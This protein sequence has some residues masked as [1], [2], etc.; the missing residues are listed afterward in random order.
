MSPQVQPSPTIHPAHDH[1]HDHLPAHLAEQSTKSVI[2]TFGKICGAEIEAAAGMI[3]CEKRV[4][5]VG[6]ISFVGDLMWTLALIL[7]HDSAEVIAKKFA[8]FDIPFDCDDMGDVVGE[9][10][11]VLAGV[12]CGNLETVGIKTN[13]SLPTVARGDAFELM[14]PDNLVSK[15]YYFTVGETDFWIDITA[16][17]SK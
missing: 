13:M 7:P 17:K 12:L 11:N 6:I 8:G 3:G 9:L 4:R 2:D 16:M 15:R 14:L 1:S 10:I 5:V